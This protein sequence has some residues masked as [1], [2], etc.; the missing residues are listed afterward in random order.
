MQQSLW[1]LKMS[2]DQGATAPWRDGVFQAHKGRGTLWENVLHHISGLRSNSPPQAPLHTAMRAD[3][4]GALP[5]R[6]AARTRRAK[7]D[8]GLSLKDLVAGTA[9]GAM[10]E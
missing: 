10:T 1:V 7:K 6:K 4:S 3:G 5:R 2:R 8:P 9:R